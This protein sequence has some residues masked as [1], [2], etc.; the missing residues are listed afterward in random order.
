[1]LLMHYADLYWCIMPNLHHDGPAF[2][3][4][5][6]AAMVSVGGFFTGALGWIMARRVLIPSRDPRLSESLALDH[7]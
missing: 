4:L 7:A 3:L 1:M 6:A 5:D 2:G